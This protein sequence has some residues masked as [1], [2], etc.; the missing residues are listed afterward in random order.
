MN[1]HLDR[2]KGI[3]EDVPLEDLFVHTYW[4]LQL[5]ALFSLVLRR[6]LAPIRF[7]IN[8]LE[9]VNILNHSGDG[10]VCLEGLIGT[11]ERKVIFA[12][13]GTTLANNVLHCTLRIMFSTFCLF[14]SLFDLYVR[15]NCSCAG[16][17]YLDL[18]L[19]HVLLL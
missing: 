13:S 12:Q 7:L 11:L 18:Y 8:V 15:S 19:G 9:G 6:T 14:F 10:M 17:L 4:I 2:G 16:E 3:A 5:S 1:P